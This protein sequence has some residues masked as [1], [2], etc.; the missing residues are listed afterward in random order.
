MKKANLCIA[1]SHTKPSYQILKFWDFEEKIQQPYFWKMVKRSKTLQNLKKHAIC[2]S[3]KCQLN[4]C[5]ISKMIHQF[6][7]SS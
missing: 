2:H 6:L 5:K 4:S 3:S 1:K 7:A